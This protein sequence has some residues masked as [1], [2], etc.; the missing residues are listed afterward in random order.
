M[1]ERHKA[2]RAIIACVLFWGFSFISI[3]VT[4]VVF[5]PMS[6]GM[7]RFAVAMVFLYFIK[8]KLAPKEKLRLLDIPLLFGAG[9]IG[10]TLYFFCENNGVSLVSASEASIAIGAIPALTMIADHI[11]G[12][13]ARTS[14]PPPAR[15]SARQWLGTGISI[16][17]V[18]LVA[19]VSLALSGSLLGYVYMAGAALSWV[20]YSLLT[21]PLFA[22]CSRIYIV[23][24][25][26][27]AGFICFLP[28]SLFELNRWGKP[29]LPVILHLLFLGIC[30]SALGYYLYVRSLE[31]LGMSVSAIFINLIPVVTVIGGFFMLGDR[32]SPLQWIGAALVIAGVYLAMGEYKNRTQGNV[33]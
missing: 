30:C 11:S 18:W 16:A 20:A 27:L 19:G 1:T 5:P 6:L 13:I 25:Q 14:G 29:D 8:Q 21:R 17:G 4:V 28:F 7:L 33:I 31:V 24:W 3:K 15:I 2:L 12:S 23:F 9:F 22:R 32:L 10:V 26:S